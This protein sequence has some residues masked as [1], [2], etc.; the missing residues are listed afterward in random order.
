MSA[1]VALIATSVAT[2]NLLMQELT[3]KA[4]AA[5]VVSYEHSRATVDEMR[6]YASCI[7]K[8][9]PEPLDGSQLI[10]VKV[11]ILV[12]LFSIA[13]GIILVRRDDEGR[14]GWVETSILGACMGLMAGIGGIMAT[15]A[16][17]FG[18]KFLFT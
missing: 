17:W 5:M 6:D 12:I 7:Q 15:A 14:S 4:C 16:I 10:T 13:A 2:N 3:R 8:L 1:T 11:A 18:V 9:H